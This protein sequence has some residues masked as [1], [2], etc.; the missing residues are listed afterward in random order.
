[1]TNPLQLCYIPIGENSQG[2]KSLNLMSY[3]K[4]SQYQSQKIWSKKISLEKS[5][6]LGLAKFGL[7]FFSVLV[8]KNLVPKKVSVSVSKNLVLEK[9]LGIGFGKFGVGKKVSV[10]VS[11]NLVSEKKSRYRFRSK[12]WYR[13]SV[14]QG[15]H[16][17]DPMG[18]SGWFDESSDDS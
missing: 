9:S 2:N 4:K 18:P 5:L 16:L 3:L 12:F 1:M 14:G 6:S 17:W 15:G 10:S 13:H 7:K 11:E 8:S